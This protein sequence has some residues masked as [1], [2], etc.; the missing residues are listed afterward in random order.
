M[1]PSKKNAARKANLAIASATL[2]QH[3]DE[4]ALEKTL[5]ES[6]SELC[7]ANKHFASLESELADKVATCSELSISLEKAELASEELQM[8]AVEQKSQYRSLYKELQLECQRSRWASEKRRTL[9][10]QIVGLKA[11][12]AIQS[13]ELKNASA[14]ACKVADSILQLERETS[15]D[16]KKLL[17]CIQHLQ[18]ELVSC[19]KRLQT[20]QKA[21]SDS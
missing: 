16:K 18:T 2:Q 13:Q 8:Q 10:Q 3:F 1:P 19:Q 5:L 7:D 14:E 21:L 17:Q 4:G 6:Q 15:V 20:T 9:E 11:A 12:A